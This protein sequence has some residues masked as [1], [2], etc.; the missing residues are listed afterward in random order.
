MAPSGH[1]RNIVDWDVTKKQK[2]PWMH[3][4]GA[5]QPAYLCS[6]FSTVLMHSL[7][8]LFY[9]SA[10]TVNLPRFLDK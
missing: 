4:I 2:K 7:I 8:V 5:D 9:F 10:Q 3:N 6:L 1:N